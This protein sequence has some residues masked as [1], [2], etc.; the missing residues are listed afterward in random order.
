MA[1]FKA[2]TV[3]W[4]HIIFLLIESGAKEDVQTGQTLTQYRIQL[5]EL[6][7]LLTQQGK[8]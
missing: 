8:L 1:K 6:R 5:D 4:A 3:E 7:K 2:E